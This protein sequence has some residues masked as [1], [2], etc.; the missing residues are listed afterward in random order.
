MPCVNN[1]LD[2]LDERNEW[3]EARVIGVDG[4]SIRI[5]YKGFVAKYDETI[6][7][8]SER[9]CPVSSRSKAYGPM[10][11]GKTDEN[12]DENLTNEQEEEFET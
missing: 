3:L 10:N 7:L 11:K 1:R 9:V 6:V 5:H 4:N 2:V 12:S 8:P